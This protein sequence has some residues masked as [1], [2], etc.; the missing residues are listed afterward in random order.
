MIQVCV[1]TSN[2]LS[3]HV[4]PPSILVNLMHRHNYD[5]I[6]SQYQQRNVAITT[7][8]RRNWDEKLYLKTIFMMDLLYM[9]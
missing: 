5:E 2:K 1:E 3:I 9:G 4:S 6:S 7:K 8:L